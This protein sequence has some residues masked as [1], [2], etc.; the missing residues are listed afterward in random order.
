MANQKLTPLQETEAK[1]RAAAAAKVNKQP[2]IFSEAEKATR[3]E[4]V[5]KAKDALARS[6]GTKGDHVTAGRAA[7]K[8]YLQNMN[9]PNQP[10]DE[11]F[12]MLIEAPLRRRRRSATTTAD[13][14]PTAAPST[15]LLT[16]CS[17]QMVSVLAGSLEPGIEAF[18]VASETDLDRVERG[19]RIGSVEGLVV[20]EIGPVGSLGECPH[21]SGEEPLTVR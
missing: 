16:L 11:R 3:K 18:E 2:R 6:V 8:K 15:R 14:E 9:E 1:R 21:M 4:R 5:G 7:L 20:V 12:E 10:D 13:S 17:G 19:L